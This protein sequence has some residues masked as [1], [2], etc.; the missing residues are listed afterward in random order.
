MHQVTRATWNEHEWCV[1]IRDLTTNLVSNDFCDI[2]INASGVLNQWQW[3]NIPDLD[4]FRGELVHSARWKKDLH[5]VGK[6]V[7]VIGNG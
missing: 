2:L 1:Q 5:L 3:P 7:G 6:N 4:T